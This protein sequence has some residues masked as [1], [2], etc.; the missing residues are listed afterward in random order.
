[1]DFQDFKPNFHH[2]TEISARCV[3][4]AIAGLYFERLSLKKYFNYFKLGVNE[5]VILT[6]FH[7]VFSMTF[8]GLEMTILKCHDFPRFSMTVRNL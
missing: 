2:Q 5:H 8:P 4:R 6:N 1:M 3:L 7:Y